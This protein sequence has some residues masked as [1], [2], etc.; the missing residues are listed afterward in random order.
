MLEWRVV[1]NNAEHR[2]GCPDALY[3]LTLLVETLNNVVDCDDGRVFSTDP[4]FDEFVS[5]GLTPC[6][7]RVDPIV[8][9]V[10]LDDLFADS[11]EAAK[12]SGGIL[13]DVS[14]VTDLDEV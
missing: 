14:I 6:Q 3:L 11:L 5:P 13:L 1:E 7:M 10:I 8:F 4:V 12:D 2:H 9:G